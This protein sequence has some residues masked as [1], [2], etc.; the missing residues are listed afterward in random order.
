M[1]KLNDNIFF[2]LDKMSS[3]LF[4]GSVGLQN[5]LLKL[6]N[7][8]SLISLNEELPNDNINRFNDDSVVP[9]NN[10]GGNNESVTTDEII[11][12]AI[13]SNKNQEDINPDITGGRSISAM[14]DNVMSGGNVN[15]ENGISPQIT[16]SSKTLEEI[17]EFKGGENVEVDTIDIKEINENTSTNDSNSSMS[18]SQSEDSDEEDERDLPP[19]EYPDDPLNTPLDGDKEFSKRY[20]KLINEIKQPFEKKNL[21]LIGGSKS[22]AKRVK[23]INAFPYILKSSPTVK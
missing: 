19:I 8:P 12:D 2:Y 3:V 7:N 5:E 4:G 1:Y 14:I 23:I 6:L 16:D 11:E 15:T 9:T 20:I 18:S 13:A 10:N 17:F 21:P 22:P